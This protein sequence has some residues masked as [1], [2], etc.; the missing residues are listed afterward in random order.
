MLGLTSLPVYTTKGIEQVM[1]HQFT[2]QLL[3]ER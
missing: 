2:V 3:S 1:L